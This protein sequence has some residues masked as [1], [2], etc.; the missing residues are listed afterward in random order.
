[1]RIGMVRTDLRKLYL[2]DLENSS[3]RNF[4]SEPRGQSRYVHRATDAELLSVLNELAYVSIRGSDNNATVD[5]TAAGDLIFQLTAGGP[6]ITASITTLAGGTAKTIIRNELNAAFT[7]LGV[8]V[9]ARI[10]GTNQIQLDTSAKGPNAYIKIDASS[11]LETVIGLSTTAVVGVP[12]ATLRTTVYPSAVTIAIG[13]ATIVALGSYAIMNTTDQTAL[14]T[15]IQDVVAPRIV[16]TGQALLSF[17][18]GVLGKLV[19]PTFQP[20]GARIGLPAGV[21]AHIVTDDG[22]ATFSL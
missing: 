17:A 1:M 9:T 6:L 7:A 22:T 11:T 5:T 3:Q 14:V 20:G 8:G 13:S 10:S 18:Y 15:A 21:A 12:V 16:E 4:S 2:S 19:D